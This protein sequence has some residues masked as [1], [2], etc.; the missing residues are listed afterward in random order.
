M[1]I[2]EL[3]KLLLISI[4]CTNDCANLINEIYYKDEQRYYEL[5]KK[6]EY[7][8]DDI[9][10][11]YSVDTTNLLNKLVGIYESCKENKNFTKIENLI[12]LINPSIIRY[13]KTSSGNVDVIK[14]FTKY[15]DYE[16]LSELE[17]VR[18]MTCLLFITLLYD[19]NCQSYDGGILLLNNYLKRLELITN[20]Y[21]NRFKNPIKDNMPIVED[22]ELKKLLNI[23][24]ENV[25][26][27]QSFS[28]FFDQLMDDIV[29]RNISKVFSFKSPNDIPLELYNRERTKIFYSDKICKYLGAFSAWFNIL[30]IEEMDL[31]SKILINNEVL[32]TIIAECNRAHKYNNIEESE[33]PLY[34]ISC[35]NLYIVAE[36]YHHSKN[37]YLNTSSEERYNQLIKYENTLKKIESDVQ[38]KE[39]KFNNK[40]VSYEE[41]VTTLKN[42]WKKFKK[43]NIKLAADN[44]RLQDDNAKLKEELEKLKADYN[45]MKANNDVLV[46][47]L[48]EKTKKP[49]L[50]IEDKCNLINKYKIGVFGGKKGIEGLSAY[51][52]NLT[53][54]SELNK[55]IS[56]LNNL[57]II[58]INTDYFNHA[59]SKKVKAFNKTETPIGFVNGTNIE[60]ILDTIYQEINTKYRSYK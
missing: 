28:L 3:E 31:E 22:E 16:G 44:N 5:Y 13:V 34:M 37:L 11:I 36:A 46:H 12:K 35:M 17:E 41:E 19:K 9:S 49:L 54:Y 45:K 10:K 4:S 14:F 50:K 15:L 38:L 32:D 57:D 47:K 8:N 60:L 24:N 59:F 6:S 42:E 23:D 20:K 26:K 18:Y 7:Y 52:N 56:S 30:G 33:L 51:L 29:H 2:E 53:F 21:V 40:V 39:E 58:F 27:E 25:L 1:K 55:D 43:E 48:E